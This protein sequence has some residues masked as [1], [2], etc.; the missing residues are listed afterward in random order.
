MGDWGD[1][2]LEND[3]A[4]NEFMSTFDELLMRLR[5]AV[6]RN[7]PEGIRVLAHMVGLVAAGCSP[8]DSYTEENAFDWQKRAT[9]SLLKRRTELDERYIEHWLTGF[10]SSFK[11]VF[12]YAALKNESEA[13][14]EDFEYRYAIWIRFQEEV[15][16]IDHDAIQ[17]EV[18]QN[19]TTYCSEPTYWD[20]I[21]KEMG[22]EA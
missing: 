12:E 14:P 17:S 19:P 15:D 2:V 6:D 16:A 8:H 13:V 10:N 22:S 4:Q 5:R 11:A 9:T 18:R 1:G 21:R 3:S 7:N 20:S